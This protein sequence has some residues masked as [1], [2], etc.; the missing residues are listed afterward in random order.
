M[1][2]S[3]VSEGPPPAINW[4]T[5]GQV[6]ITFAHRQ[7]EESEQDWG[8]LAE[9]NKDSREGKDTRWKGSEK[10]MLAEWIATPVHER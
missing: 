7:K 1:F 4:S 10:D 5:C 3:Q 8:E 2:L 9:A 6:A